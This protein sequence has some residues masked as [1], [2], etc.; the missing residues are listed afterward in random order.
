MGLTGLWLMEGS[1]TS[2]TTLRVGL[3]G[4]TKLTLLWIQSQPVLCG[5]GHDLHFTTNITTCRDV[6]N[7][8]EVA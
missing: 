7:A 8:S 3:V 6:S 5:R 1:P 4:L 2:P